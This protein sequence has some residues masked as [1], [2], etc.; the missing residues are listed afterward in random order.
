MTG[1]LVTDELWETIEPLLPPEPPPYS[2]DLSLIEAAFSKIKGYRARRRLV[3]T[4]C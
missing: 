4:R 1:E 3:L 2:P